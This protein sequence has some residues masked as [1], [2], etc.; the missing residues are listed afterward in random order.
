MA[1]SAHQD[2]VTHLLSLVEAS[3]KDRKRFEGFRQSALEYMV[4]CKPTNVGLIAL[5]K[6]MIALGKLTFLDL[7]QRAAYDELLEGEYQDSLRKING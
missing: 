7:D 4:A 2:F 3:L 6:K 5:R 1:T